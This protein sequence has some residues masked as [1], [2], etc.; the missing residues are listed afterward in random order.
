MPYNNGHHFFTH[1]RQATGGTP[2]AAAS[3]QESHGTFLSSLNKAG[4]RRMLK[5]WTVI[6]SNKKTFKP[7]MVY[8]IQLAQTAAACLGNV[9]TKNVPGD[10]LPL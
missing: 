2:F 5:T 9:Y 4:K 6:E 3:Y 1:A 8:Y 7:E 10:Q